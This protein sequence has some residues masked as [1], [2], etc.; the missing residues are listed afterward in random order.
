VLF[1]SNPSDKTRTRVSGIDRDLNGNLWVSIDRAI[2]P[3]VVQTPEGEWF[4][5]AADQFPT[6]PEDNH[7]TDLIVDQLGTVWMV[8]YNRNLWAYSSN[9]T[10][11][12]WQDG[13]LLT[14]LTGIN[15]GGL[16]SDQVFAVAEDQEG[17]IWVGTAQ[18]VSV[19]FDPFT[20]SR[21]Q[22][23]D[24]SEPIFGQRRLLENTSINAIAVDGGNRKWIGTNDGVYLVSE[25][26]DDVIQ[27]FNTDNSPLISDQVTDVSIDPSTGEVYFA[28]AKGLISYQGDAVAG[29]AQCEDVL[30]YPNP[31]F[32]DY[33]GDIA[34]RGM[35]EGST[36]KITT[37]SGLLVTELESLGGL[38][39]WDGR[40]HRG[41]KVRSGVYLALI[42]DR[43]GDSACTGKFVVIERGQ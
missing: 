26:G 31:V 1:R 30:V 15:Q 7:I 33:G 39:T 23:V 11:D 16:P 43:N 36:V 2:P 24:G 18:G 8:N 17:F 5:V 4:E 6:N 38:A 34:I 29:N 40:D 25:N 37:V 13:K 19:I 42:S 21:G 35:S 3:L 12:D 22:V 10:P 41:R 27:E 9:G 28:T 20:V 14:F 32:T